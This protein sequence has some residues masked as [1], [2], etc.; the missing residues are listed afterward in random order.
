[1]AIADTKRVL[2]QTTFP[3]E[4]SDFMVTA[5][6]CQLANPIRDSRRQD[7]TIPLPVALIERCE[8]A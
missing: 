5:G 8:Y 1:M 3:P 7:T 6:A 2:H 4:V